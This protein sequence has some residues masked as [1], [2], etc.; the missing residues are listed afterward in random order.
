MRLKTKFAHSMITCDYCLRTFSS[1]TIFERH[2]TF[3][4]TGKPAIY[5]AEDPVMKFKNYQFRFVSPA[6]MYAD[7]EAYNVEKNEEISD[8][9]SLIREQK[10]TG[11]GYTIVSPFPNLC[12][13]VVVY[14]GVDAAERFVDALMTECYNLKDVLEN[15][16]PMEFTDEDS[17]TYYNS[18][19]CHICLHSLDWDSDTNPVC[20][21]HCH[22]TGYYTLIQKLKI[23]TTF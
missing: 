7:F 8:K 9:T 19:I 5:I 17:E 15:V 11:F 14:R 16:E 20:R 21:D 10:P 3:C 13:P 18:D 23:I 2:Q 12:R 6:V 22:V 1:K 4:E